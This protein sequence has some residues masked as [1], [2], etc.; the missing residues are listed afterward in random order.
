MPRTHSPSPVSSR[1]RERILVAVLGLAAM[2]VSMM[3]TLVVPVLG[4]IQDDLRATAADTSWLTSATL[5]SAAVCTPLLGRLADQ[6]GTK[7]VLIGVL[8]VTLAGSVLGAT[9]GTLPWLIVAR[10]LQGASTA[11][12]ALAQSV[13]RNELPARR[14]PGSMGLISGTLAFGNGLA[15]VGAG[16]LTQGPAP[17]YHRVFW[18]A[19]V[20]SGLALI[21]TAVAVPHTGAPGGGRTDWLGAVLL[22]AMLTLLL[23][24]LS[25]VAVWGWA[26]GTTLGCFAGSAVT[27]AVWALVERRVRDPLVDLR[28]FALRTVVFANLV[29]FLLGFAMFSQFLGTSALVQ[30]PG[31]PAGYGFDA[32]VLRASVG[33]L[34]PPAV[35][36]LIAAQVA[37]A[38]ARRLGARRTLASGAAFGVVGFA[39]LAFAYGRPA[40]VLTG[41]VLVGIAIAFGFAT[42]PA[43]LLDAV[44]RAQTG[45]ANGI[46]SVCRSVGSA[47]ASALLGTLLAA[48]ARS[49]VPAESHFTLAFGL[50]GGAFA[51]VVAVALRGLRAPRTVDARPGGSHADRAGEAHTASTTP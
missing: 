33:Y 43:V 42:L 20:L 39:L 47:V 31:A 19:A 32:T 5:L 49:G 11:V 51:V 40:S 9:A 36:S 10:A 25:R 46:N 44:P 41:G 45:V 21:A 13:L 24:P 6:Y 17:D 4:V 35:A 34:L 27:A 12:F 28:V 7:P 48:T 50:A 14:L 3:Q 37:G 18:A 29:G 2:V 15:L 8:T 1:S 23:L 38:L 26:S 22:A 16:L 30:L